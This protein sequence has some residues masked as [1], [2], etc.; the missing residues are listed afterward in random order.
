M[1]IALQILVVIGG[2]FFLSQF[3][4][5]AIAIATAVAR[6]K[7]TESERLFHARSYTQVAA[8]QGA[9]VFETLPKALPGTEDQ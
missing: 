6:R 2:L 3:V 8:K 5:V 9:P 7:K 4:M 1:A